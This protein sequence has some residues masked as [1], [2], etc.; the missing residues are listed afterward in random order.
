MKCKLLAAVPLLSATL[1]LGGVA[2]AVPLPARAAG[3]EPSMP[4]AN[5]EVTMTWVSGHHRFATIDGTLHRIGDTLPDGSRVVNI[6]KGVVTLSRA[7]KLVKVQIVSAPPDRESA[8]TGAPT[9]TYTPL[10]YLDD[11]IGQLDHAIAM[12]AGRPGMR[13]Q[14]DQLRRL[15]ERLSA[16]RRRL[17]ANDLSPGEKARLNKEINRQWLKAQAALDGLRR[18][19]LNSGE[20]LSIDQLRATENTLED[21]SVEALRK[22]LAELKKDPQFKAFLKDHPDNLAQ[23][24]AALL[25]SYP[26]YQA[27][28]NQLGRIEQGQKK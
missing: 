23:V 27:L 24:A 6:Q 18:R 4:R 13:A 5:H 7:G 10:S 12:R 19:I 21:A 16:D 1:V 17:A 11:A 14:V 22:P 9:P 2:A 20:A 25:G 26:D 8:A 15:R 3:T 28:A